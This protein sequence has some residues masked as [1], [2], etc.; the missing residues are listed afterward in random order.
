[1]HSKNIRLWLVAMLLWLPLL[2]SAAADLKIQTP[3][4][5]SLK[6]AMHERHGQM[7]GYFASGA[8][9]LTR[10]GLVALRDASL[11]PLAQRQAANSMVT[12]ENQDRKT[13]YRELALANGHPEWEEEIQSTFAERWARKAPSGWWYQNS[14]G[15]WV[16]K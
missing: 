6:K 5:S 7:T 3:A 8:I 10:D 11:V 15:A 1:M 2:A 4:I 9:G 12:A 14:D 13:L 16:Q